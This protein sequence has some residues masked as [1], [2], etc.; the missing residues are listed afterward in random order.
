[1]GNPLNAYRIVSA[2]NI[3]NSRNSLGLTNGPTP[4]ARNL[5]NTSY[6]IT[7]QRLDRQRQSLG[8]LCVGVVL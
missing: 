4:L 7:Y 8:P 6:Y 5:D 2:F 1:M 3:R